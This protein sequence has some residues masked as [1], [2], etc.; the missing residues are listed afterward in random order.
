MLN[1]KFYRYENIKILE[2]TDIG[3]ATSGN[4]IRGQHIYNPHEPKKQITDIVSLT[5]IGKNILENV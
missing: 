5:V 3:I 2:L 1:L 4:A